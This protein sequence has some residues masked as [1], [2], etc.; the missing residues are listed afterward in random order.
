MVLGVESE[1]T[2]ARLGAAQEACGDMRN[3]RRLL[4][5][6]S[7]VALAAA[8]AVGGGL[9][10]LRAGG[11]LESLELGAYDRV[12]RLRPRTTERSAPITLVR[13]VEADI[14]RF[15]HP[16]CD[17]LLARAIEKLLAAGPRVVGIDLYRDTPVTS[18]ADGEGAGGPSLERVVTASDRIVM[19]MK[20]PDEHGV[21]TPPPYFLRDE[22]F[23]GFSDLPVD[24]GG[25]TRRGLLYLWDGDDAHV[26]FSLRLALRYLQ[27]AGIALAPDANDPNVVRLADASIPPFHGWDGAYVRADDGGY[28][29][30]LDYADGPDAFRAFTLGDLFADR[31]P[32]AELAGRIAI[33]GTTS[34][35]VKDEFYTPWNRERDEGHAMSGLEVHAHAASQFLRIA[36]GESRPIASASESAESAWILLFAGGGALLGLWNRSA[37]AAASAALAALASLAVATWAAFWQGLWIP[38][39]PPALALIGAAGLVTLCVAVIERIERREVT[40]LFSRFLRP[41]VA[42]EIWRQ[43]DQFMQG[44]QQAGRPRSQRAVISVLMSDLTGYTETSE[45]IDPDAL[46]TWVNDYMTA[47]ADVIEKH[48]GVVDDYAGDGIKANFGFPVPRRSAP[49]IDTDAANA[50][51]CALAMDAAMAQLNDDWRRKHLPTGRLRVG[52]FTG[53]AVVGALGGD[54]SL[55]FTSVGDVVNTAAR[56]ESFDSEGF[57]FDAGTSRILIG[58]ETWRRSGG[59]FEAV[60]L[61]VHAL[62]GKAEKIRIFRLMVPADRTARAGSGSHEEGER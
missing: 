55:K 41:K 44:G 54:E 1:G 46:M 8:A 43:R 2:A 45:K 58:E 60:D 32:E 7:F 40:R 36:R 23:V 25:T 37:V 38:I 39:V 5:S 34:P 10:L 29:F 11:F 61:G 24:P 6:R 35:S 3:T 22:R 57:S 62:K 50:V 31:V 26:S 51:R 4:R 59:E 27:D 20:F 17:R 21:G 56:L 48:D 28:Q 14:R 49:E 19:V 33:L 47:M 53:P 42:E 15:G 52:I 30:L 9:L 12:I 13:I 18:C 16:L